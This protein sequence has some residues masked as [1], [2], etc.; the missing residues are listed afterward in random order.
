MGA[1]SLRALPVVLFCLG[2]SAAGSP[3]AFLQPDQSILEA[4]QQLIAA[5]WQPA[6]TQTPSERERQWA[7]VTLSSL[8][9]CS[10]SGAGFCRFDYQ[11]QEKRLSV[12]TVP[13]KPGKPSIGRVNRW[14]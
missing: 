12:V 2:A 3:L 6:P 13:S 9:S 8:S 5:G 1:L 14:W 7:A 11:R 4:H 10:G